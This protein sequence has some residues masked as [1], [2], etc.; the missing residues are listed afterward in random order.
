V[1][2]R[3]NLATTGVQQE[4]VVAMWNVHH[5]WIFCGFWFTAKWPL[6]S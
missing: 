6:F 2:A 5:I 1:N 3:N 4:V